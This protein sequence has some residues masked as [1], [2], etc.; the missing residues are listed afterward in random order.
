MEMQKSLGEINA[1]ILSLR[2]SVDSVKSKVDDL[3]AWKNKILGGAAVFGAV[4]ALL[5]FLFTKFSDY[6]TIASPHKPQPAI[7]S[8]ASPQQAPQGGDSSRPM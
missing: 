2:Q 3:V 4:C 8:H 1:S 5:G 7:E 6:V